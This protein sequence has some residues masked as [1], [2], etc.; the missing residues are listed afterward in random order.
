MG[1]VVVNT[2]PEASILTSWRR[3]SSGART[4]V[5]MQKVLWKFHRIG[6]TS[7]VRELEKIE[8]RVSFQDFR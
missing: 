7:G 4:L 6:V 1:D 2:S 8:R 5:H 3:W